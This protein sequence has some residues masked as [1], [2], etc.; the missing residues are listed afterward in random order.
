MVKNFIKKNLSD[1]L[2]YQKRKLDWVRLSEIDS[3]AITKADWYHP[4][5]PVLGSQQ[6]S[7]P[8]HQTDYDPSAN[9]FS[10]NLINEVE[11]YLHRHNTRAFLIWHNGKMVHKHYINFD[12]NDTF[13]SMSL[14]K[15]VM[16]LCIGIAIDHGM[17]Q[18][19]NEPIHHYFPEW[20]NTAHQHITIEHLL[21]MQ[22]G[23]FS[24]VALKGLSP[25]P[26]IV[27]LYLGNDIRKTVMSINAVAPPEKYFIYN[28]YNSQLL[29]LILE[30]ASGMSVANFV[31][32]YL[33]QPLRCAD[34]FFWTDN[35]GVARTFSGFFARPV[36]WMKLGQLLV[37][38]GTYR[39]TG[40]E[41]DIVS[42]SWITAMMTPT[43]TLMRG[44]KRGKADYGYHLWLKAHDYGM[45][46]GIPTFEG[47]FATC[48]HVDESVVYFEGLR[49]QYVFASPK[50]NLVV[51]RMGERPCRDWDASWMINKLS[52]AL[53]NSN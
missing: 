24:D 19:V 18:G 16:G 12:E 47:E 49:A 8:D 32:K 34:A 52:N 50:N 41:V 10:S 2:S 43:N 25:F 33:W 5:Q 21:T 39:E 36:D 17:I 22:S 15:S 53:D 30:R 38:G 37:N 20:Q 1:G 44:V 6:P 7:Q 3:A 11:C 35:H 42:P 9:P 48:A 45:I 13:N 4:R 31:S 28:N 14:V 40:Y 27:P 29:G 26:P 23:L 51:M 46:P